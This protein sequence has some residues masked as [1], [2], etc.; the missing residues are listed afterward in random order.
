MSSKPY[1]GPSVPDM[2]RDKTLAENIIRYHNHPAS[3][4][5]LDD[6]NLNLLQRFVE[7]PSKREEILRGEDINPDESL[8]GKQASLAAYAV[9]AHGRG[10]MSGGILKDSDIEMLRSWFGE[11]KGE[12]RV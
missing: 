2:I 12:A 7:D 4:S 8:E 3:D 11:G 9:W 10:D 5:M 6:D 1:T